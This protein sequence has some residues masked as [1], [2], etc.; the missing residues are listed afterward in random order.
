MFCDNKYVI[1]RNLIVIFINL[2][3]ILL[4]YLFSVYLFFIKNVDLFYVYVLLKF[5]YW[6]FVEDF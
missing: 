6:M 1:I 4:R 2:D 5:E 3:I